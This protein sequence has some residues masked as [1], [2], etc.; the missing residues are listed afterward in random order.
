MLTQDLHCLPVGPFTGQSA[1]ALQIIFAFPQLAPDGAVEEDEAEHWA[2]EV[3]GGHPQHDVQLPRAD[4]VAGVLALARVEV[5]MRL[6]VVLHGD[7]EERGGGGDQGE[8]PQGEDDVLHP[9]SGHHHLAAQGEADGQVA[10]DAQRRD[11]EDAGRGAALEDVVVEAAHGLAKQPGH[12]LPQAVQ[13]KGQAHED[14]QVRHGHAGQVQVGG[15]FHVLEMLDDED[16]HGV[17]RHT[18]DEDEDADD[19]DGDEGG[20]REEGSL[21]VVV[22]HAVRIADL[23]P[24]NMGV[25]FGSGP[26]HHKLRE[27]TS[28]FRENMR[29]ITGSGICT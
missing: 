13:V 29:I 26:G 5:R 2:E 15:G 21:V 7:Q 16:G 22:V 19:G 23:R 20:R 12:V 28:S 24:V 3:G 14:D 8:H 6:V 4:G 25:H 27:S 10:L 11:V 9:A 18:H 1:R 17:A